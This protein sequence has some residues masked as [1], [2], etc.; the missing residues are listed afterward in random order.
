[1]LCIM[2]VLW[3]LIRIPQF[4][5]DPFRQWNI[6]YGHK[7]FQCI[8]YSYNS[9]KVICFNWK[10]SEKEKEHKTNNNTTIEVSKKIKNKNKRETI[11]VIFEY[12]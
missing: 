6:E 7:K 1:M 8:F 12:L 11:Y 9:T 4:L 2:C 10:R 5:N 3:H